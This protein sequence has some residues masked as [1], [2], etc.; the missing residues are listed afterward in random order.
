MEVR[1]IR[2]VE[3]LLAAQSSSSRL[4]KPDEFLW[5]EAQCKQW[6]LSLFDGAPIKFLGCE[7]HPAAFQHR[8][9]V[10]LHSHGNPHQPALS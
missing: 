2:T 1:S 6:G 5:F 10:S 4:M 9:Q 3:T 7:S 8:G